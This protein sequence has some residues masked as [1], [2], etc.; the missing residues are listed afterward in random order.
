MKFIS[1]VAAIATI[2]GFAAPAVA[3]ADN[4]PTYMRSSLYTILV[5]SDEQNQ[6]LQKQIDE[7]KT[8]EFMAVAKGFAN[9]D[10]KKAANDSM[11]DIPVVEIPL[12]KFPNI[13]IPSQFNDH[14]LALRVI[15]YDAIKATVTDDEKKMYAEKKSNGKKFG[16]FAKGLAAAT[17]SSQAG[18]SNSAMLST[19]DMEDYLPAVIAKSFQG[20]HTAADLIGKWFGYENGAW[21][22][23]VKLIQE[24][25]LQ[26]ASA[27][28]LAKAKESGFFASNLAGKG[29]DL[30]NNTYVLAV[31]LRFR[32]NQAVVAESQAMAEGVFGGIGK[33]AGAVASAAAGE[34]FQV[35]AV[36]YLYKLDWNDEISTEFA[37]KYFDQNK[38]IED[39]VASGL[40][41]LSFVGKDK[42]GCNVRQSLFN[43]TPQSTLIE[44]ATA[45]AIDNAICK[46]QSKHEVFRTIAPISR[47][48]ED[49]TIYAGIGL[50]EDL[51]KG[52]KYEVL[53]A[54]EDPETGRVTYKA[55]A[56]V[57]PDE[58][59]IWDN[60]YGAAEELAEKKEEKNKGA[61]VKDEEGVSEDAANLM[62][63]AFK[64]KK[65]KDYT[66]YFLRLK[67]KK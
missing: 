44:R 56:T 34:G 42:A 53:E 11:A 27:E 61:E 36:T 33:L 26:N 10:A 51:K 18:T 62:A 45:R 13:P 6:R 4:E 57:E 64:G 60:R 7:T 48:D 58:T 65:G 1:K 32:S 67:K 17:M 52:D 30:I 19:D 35:Q 43:T 29:F 37:E 25:G 55:V 5:K 50:K 15:D 59:R 23:D 28:D 12:L 40:C 39:L 9:T 41:K 24:R 21:D 49:G 31:N 8:N 3:L 63:S 54:I 22:K 38:S 20:N 47:C 16:A 66:G 2:V 46:L 14:N